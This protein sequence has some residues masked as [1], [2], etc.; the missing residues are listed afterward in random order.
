MNSQLFQTIVG[1]NGIIPAL[2]SS[3]GSSYT[4]RIEEVFDFLLCVKDLHVHFLHSFLLLK[5]E[6]LSY[7]CRMSTRLDGAGQGNCY[8][9]CLGNI[10]IMERFIKEDKKNP[11]CSEM[12]DSLRTK[13]T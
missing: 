8:S 6:M 3:V 10:H 9:M 13:S 4:L 11:S 1:N 2:S 12:S 5:H 7:P